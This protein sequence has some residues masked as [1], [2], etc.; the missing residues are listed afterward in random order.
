MN[1]CYI[2][3]S[4]LYLMYHKPFGCDKEM[5]HYM[6]HFERGLCDA[7]SPPSGRFMNNIVSWLEVLGNRSYGIS[8]VK[9]KTQMK[10]RLLAV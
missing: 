8:L 6:S 1:V 3:V 7:L 10:N 4:Y 9:K 5:F 2:G